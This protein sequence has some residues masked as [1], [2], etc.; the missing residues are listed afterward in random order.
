VHNIITTANMSFPGLAASDHPRRT[1]DMIVVDQQYD[2]GRD[3]V[4]RGVAFSHRCSA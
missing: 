2:T 3:L 4:H 1:A